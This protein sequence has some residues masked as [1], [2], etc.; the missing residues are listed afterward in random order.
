MQN[1]I[2]FPR[3]I[4][5]LGECNLTTSF[6]I[7]WKE[8]CA[9]RLR[10]AVGAMRRTAL[11]PVGPTLKLQ[12]VPTVHERLCQNLQGKG[13]GPLAE[14]QNLLDPLLWPGILPVWILGVDLAPLI[15]PC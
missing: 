14:W 1:A 3:W 15:K 8:D 12:P 10:L 9:N 5:E 13:A 6:F 11:E 2:D 4:G 7:F